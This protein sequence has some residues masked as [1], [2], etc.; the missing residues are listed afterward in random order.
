MQKEDESKNTAKQNEPGEDAIRGR[1]HNS[2]NPDFDS[3]N[4]SHD[5]SS[6]DQQEGT[7]KHGE[8]GGNFTQ[9]KDQ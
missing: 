4:A 3:E 5:I 1:V 7:M 8:S 6:V 9:K 2:Q